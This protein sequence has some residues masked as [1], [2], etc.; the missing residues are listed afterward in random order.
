M[1]SLELAAHT[2]DVVAV[3]DVLRSSSFFYLGNCL[4][5][6]LIDLRSV[7][8]SPDEP[9]AEI[10]YRHFF[11]PT[12]EFSLSYRQLNFLKW[13]RLFCRC[14]VYFFKLFLG[15]FSSGYKARTPLCLTY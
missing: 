4:F 11:Q 10:P 5:M 13:G 8:V 15:N 12:V 6:S 2:Y 1:G 9:P 14:R 7:L 3:S